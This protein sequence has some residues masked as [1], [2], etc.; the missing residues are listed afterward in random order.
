MNTV[1]VRIPGAEIADTVS[2]HA[3]MARALGLPSFY[4]A[5]FDA[6]IDCLRS[7]DAPADGMVDPAINPGELMLLQIDDADVFRRRCPREYD[8]LIEV[9]GVVNQARVQAGEPPVLA[10][11]PIGA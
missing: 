6:L 11:A 9:V 7:V 10:L 3:V 2:F 4:G 8:A 1:V 5:N